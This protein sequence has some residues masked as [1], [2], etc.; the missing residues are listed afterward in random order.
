MNGTLSGSGNSAGDQRQLQCAS[1]LR[2]VGGPNSTTCSNRT[3]AFGPLGLCVSHNGSAI[4]Y[5]Y[6]DGELHMNLDLPPGSLLSNVPGDALFVQS[7]S[8]GI[9]EGLRASG[10]SVRRGDVYDVLVVLG[11]GCIGTTDII[12]SYKVHVTSQASAYQLSR[13]LRSTALHPFSSAFKA[14]V[15]KRTSSHIQRLDVLEPLVHSQLVLVTTPPP[16]VL[17]TPPVTPPPQPPDNTDHSRLLFGVGLGV[18]CSLLFFGYIC[19]RRWRRANRPRIGALEAGMQRHQRDAIG[20][21]QVDAGDQP[22]AQAHQ[23]NVRKGGLD[24]VVPSDRAS[25]GV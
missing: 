3:R 17:V 12:V 23:K 9:V 7:I 21:S 14:L 15:I 24:G 16:V 13:S 8:Q 5:T 18:L 25:A 1:G 22:Q 11:A 2:V 6:V 10:H 20:F 19:F 4:E